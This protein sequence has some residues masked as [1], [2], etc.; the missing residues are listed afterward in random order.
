ML[1]GSISDAS[2]SRKLLVAPQITVLFYF[3][4]TYV[5]VLKA[6]STKAKH[7]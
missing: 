6:F 7:P 4:D 5:E 2:E 3:K 1:G